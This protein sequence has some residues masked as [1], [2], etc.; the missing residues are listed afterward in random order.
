M[1]WTHSLRTEPLFDCS[2]ATSMREVISMV[3]VLI[4]SS[5]SPLSA[6]VSTFALCSVLASV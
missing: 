4:L 5:V 1:H 2:L 6:E 3:A